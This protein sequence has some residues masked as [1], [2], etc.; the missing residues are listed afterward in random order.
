ME[1]SKRI[2]N[3]CNKRIKNAKADF[4]KENLEN[5]IGNQKKFWKTIQEVIPAKQSKGNKPMIKLIDKSS[6]NP[7]PEINTASFINDFFVN[8]G[9]NLAKNCNSQWS[10]D[11]IRNLNQIDDIVTNVDEVIKL[12]K[13]INIDKSSCIDQISSQVIRDAFLAIPEKIVQL[14]NLSFE[15][16][17]I[18]DSWKIAKVTPLQKPGNKS[19]VSNL[20]P[21][22]L[23][24]I[25]SKLIEKIVH[26]R[27]YKHCK[28]NNILDKKQGGF[29][30]N[31]STTKSTAFFINDIYT[32]I[33]NNEMLI[34]TFIDAMKAFDT[35]N[36]NILLKKMKLYGVG[37]K[38]LAWLEDYLNERYQ[39]TIANNVVSELKKITY[40]VPQGTV[41][42]PLLFLIYINDLS[43][44]LE[45]CRVSLYADDTVLYIPHRDAEDAIHLMQNDLNKLAVWCNENRITI[46]S[47]KTKY[48]IFGSRSN[49]KKSKSVDTI[50]SLNNCTLDRV[51]SYK[52]L[53]FRLDDHLTFNKHISELSNLVTHKLYLLS[54]IRRYITFEASLTIFKT[55]V[56][57]IIEYGDIIYSGTSIRNLNKID[58]LFYRGLRICLGHQIGLSKDDLCHECTITPLLGR[59]RLHLLLF[60]H[61]LSANKDMLKMTSIV[62]R[63]HE[64]PVFWLYKPEN[65]KARLNILYRGALEWNMLLAKDR[66][67]DFNDFKV[68]YKRELLS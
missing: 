54:K 30:P 23:L 20:R 13:A 6:G 61:K 60:M 27:I 16:A 65:E 67:L 8:I 35:V 62:T 44:V 31:H 25:P 59:R 34:A 39:C 32:A 33:N 52:Y 28:E 68:M 7:V 9:P 48:C 42:G 26:N 10:F 22:S 45:H 36:H 58:T 51:C 1:G 63:L 37:G 56:L 18:P 12:C 29:R 47:K 4:I 55:M 19:D 40:G 24:P 15:L 41:C 21:V 43:H 38:V 57:S 11:G 5:N 49:I 14:F 53:G 66:N 17:D 3:R 2:R 50:I 46:N 64:A